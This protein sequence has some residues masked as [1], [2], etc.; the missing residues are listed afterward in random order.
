MHQHCRPSQRALVSAALGE[1][2]NADGYEQACERVTAV[3]E[4]LN[5][6]APKVAE[7][8]AEAEEDLLAFY[9]LPR[10]ALEQAP[11]HQPA[12]ARQPRDRPPLRRRRHLSQRR[13]VDPARRHAADRAEQ[14]VARR[15]PLPVPG[16]PD[17]P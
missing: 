5:P 3:I 15:P 4:Q 17:R 1:V 14:R 12:R 6:V 7:L 9:P 2:F 16:I 10:R 11:K 13:R 8:L